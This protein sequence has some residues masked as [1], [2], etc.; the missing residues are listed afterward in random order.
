MH[1]KTIAQLGS[2]CYAEH[3]QK[4]LYS[5]AD[6]SLWFFLVFGGL[7]LSSTLLLAQGISNPGNTLLFNA[8]DLPFIL[9]ALLYGT[10]RFSLSLGSITDNFKIPTLVLSVLS[11]L[12]FLLVLF[13][14]FGFP[15]AKLL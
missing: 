3:M 6:V 11:G 5:L 1:E 8:L 10:A 2:L 13:L 9:S 7:H 4:A 15:D 12:V 14:N